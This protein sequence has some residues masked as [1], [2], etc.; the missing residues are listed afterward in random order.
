MQVI[1]TLGPNVYT[2]DLHWAMWISRVGIKVNGEFWRHPL[3]SPTTLP[4]HENCSGL[5]LPSCVRFP[6]PLCQIWVSIFITI[7]S[8]GIPPALSLSYISVA[9][10]L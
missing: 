8:T 7:P 1:P 6:L 10:I 4:V 2:Y 3:Y 5:A 9:R